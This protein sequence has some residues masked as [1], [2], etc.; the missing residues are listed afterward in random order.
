MALRSDP[1]LTDLL[2]R[3]RSGLAGR[4]PEDL[5]V[6]DDQIRARNED[7]I[8]SPGIDEGMA[9]WDAGVAEREVAAV[10]RSGAH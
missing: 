6:T 5:F 4:V 9:T 2:Y 3:R 10:R 1:S 8:N 7:P